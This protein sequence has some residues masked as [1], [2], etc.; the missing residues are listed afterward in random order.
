MR[1]DISGLT[2]KP[3]TLSHPSPSRIAMGLFLI[4]LGKHL[5]VL[6]CLLILG[7]AAGRFDVSQFAIFIL[8]VGSATSHLLGKA[9]L[10]PAPARRKLP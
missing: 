9:Y 7:R 8:I 3:E 4:K 10:N 1:E 5:V 6:A 2:A